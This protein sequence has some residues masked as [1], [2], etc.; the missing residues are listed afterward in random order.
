MSARTISNLCP[1][2][3]RLSDRYINEKDGK[4]LRRLLDETNLWK[5]FARETGPADLVAPAD[6][7]R[8]RFYSPT[9]A[10]PHRRIGAAGQG[11]KA[12][13]VISPFVHP[14]YWPVRRRVTDLCYRRPCGI[15]C[16]VL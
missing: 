16:L 1:A 12:G 8:P 9:S 13:A 6:N 7:K 15:D 2:R 10:I 3:E 11:W 4:T 5:R 14:S